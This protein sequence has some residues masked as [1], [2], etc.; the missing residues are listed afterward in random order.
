MLMD[1]PLVVSAKKGL[2]ELG[3][4]DFVLQ[5]LDADVEVGAELRSVSVAGYFHFSQM[6]TLSVGAGNHPD[7]IVCRGRGIGKHNVQVLNDVL[8]V[9]EPFAVGELSGLLLLLRGVLLARPLVKVRVVDGSADDFLSG[10]PRKGRV[11]VR[12]P[13]LVTPFDFVDPRSAFGTRFGRCEDQLRG[14]YVLLFTHVNVVVIFRLEAPVTHFHA[15]NTALM[16]PA[17]DKASTLVRG[18]R[19]HDTGLPFFPETQSCRLRS[20]LLGVQKFGDDVLEQA[21][22]V[23]PVTPSR[24]L[25]S[26][27]R[28]V[29]FDEAQFFLG[30]ALE[31]FIGGC[32]VPDDGDPVGGEVEFDVVLFA[33]YVQ[34]L[35][36]L[37]RFHCATVLDVHLCLRHEGDLFITEAFLGAL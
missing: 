20:K 36:H 34:V 37:D 28:R 4:C 32:F 29:V 5:P 17:R 14:L 27:V 26:N 2:F 3:V 7:E 16:V 22:Q 6:N 15:T 30:V 10:L 23:H 1:D 8:H 18:T 11:A 12:A 21:R 33:D 13:H 19:A 9:G 25:E 35:L 31:L 24:N